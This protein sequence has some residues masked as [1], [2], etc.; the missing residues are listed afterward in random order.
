MGAEEVWPD[1]LQGPQATW[2]GCFHR[3]CQARASLEPSSQISPGW[4]AEQKTSRV[5]LQL[6]S[7]W[8]TR[9][10]RKEWVG[11]RKRLPSF[12]HRGH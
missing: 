4:M 6:I 8:K 11:G 2:E 5:S 3:C 10:T 12:L 9:E 1:G 7:K